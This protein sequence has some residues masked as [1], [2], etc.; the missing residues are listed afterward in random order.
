M[1]LPALATF[2]PAG[3]PVVVAVGSIGLEALL[4]DRLGR[5]IHDRGELVTTLLVHLGHVAV[6]LVEVA[7]VAAPVAFVWSHRL[8][9]IDATRPLGLVGLVVAFEFLY[10]WYHRASH[11]IRWFWATH[12]VHHSATRINL[13]AALR[14]GW[15]GAISGSFVFFLPLVWAGW[16]P[17][18]VAAM[19]AADLAYQF[20]LHT[21]LLPALGPLEWV[22]NTPRHHCVHHAAN[23]DCLD[24]NYGGM[25][26][27]FDRLFGTFAAAPAEPLR[28]G[29]IGQI[30]RA[31][32]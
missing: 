21:E 8:T 12:V 31:H 23:P 3:V 28:Y 16:S 13:T 14:L 25:T 24:R 30:G 11:R 27:V 2:A 9:T 17:T 29:A 4:A 22:L 20:F 6:R 7:I 10:Y 5:R 32:V 19:T 26:I 1:H 18:A 15:T